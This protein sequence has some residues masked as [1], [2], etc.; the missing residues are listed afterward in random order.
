MIP[1]PPGDA[2]DPGPWGLP[3][4]PG[5]AGE[6]GFP[7]TPGERGWPGPPGDSGLT[8]LRGPAGPTGEAGPPGTPGTCVCQETEVV[9]ADKKQ[10]AYDLNKALSHPLVIRVALR[11]VGALQLSRS[12]PSERPPAPA[13]FEPYI[14]AEEFGDGQAEFLPILDG[15][16]AYYNGEEINL[17][18]VP[19]P[20]PSLFGLRTLA[21][22]AV[23][24]TGL[25]P[26]GHL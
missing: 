12:A 7:G 4:H 20:L 1:G 9:I 21:R 6:S 26:G 11:E 15:D 24:R 23:R 14:P 19:C 8:G 16:N 17:D 3:G 22:I 13:A 10:A 18:N 2:G 25:G 5:L